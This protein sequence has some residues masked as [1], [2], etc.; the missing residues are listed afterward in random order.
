MQIGR[1]PQ[2]VDYKSPILL[3]LAGN[4]FW[5]ET[6]FDRASRAVS[7]L[8]VDAFFLCLTATGII[9]IQATNNKLQ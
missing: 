1:L 6:S 7:Q 8:Q 4:N 5:K 2:D 3:F 9:Y